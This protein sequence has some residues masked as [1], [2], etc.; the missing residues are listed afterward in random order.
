MY[1]PSGNASTN[2]KGGY[3]NSVVAKCIFFLAKLRFQPSRGR[4]LDLCNPFEAPLG[5]DGGRMVYT[6][7]LRLHASCV[8]VC[9][10]RL[11]I[12]L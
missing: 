4:L 1:V 8:A 6:N 5:R 3:N 12:L 2:M 10:V 9:K 11:S 7:H